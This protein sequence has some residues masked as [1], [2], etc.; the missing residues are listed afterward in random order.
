[1]TWPLIIRREAEKD[2][3][4]GFDWYEERRHGLGYEFLREVRTLLSTIETNPQRHA[5][6]YRGV[7][8]ALIKRFPYKLL[9]L[10]SSI[11]SR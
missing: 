7:R 8:M 11:V 1:V 2:M 6:T 9:Y 5:E 10:L 3:A 4:E